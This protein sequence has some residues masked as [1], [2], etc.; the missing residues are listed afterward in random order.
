MLHASHN[1]AASLDM[2]WLRPNI[3]V[4]HHFNSEEH[5][6]RQRLRRMSAGADYFS[7]LQVMR[8]LTAHTQPGAPNE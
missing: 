5:V 6:F 7:S 2:L 4:R 8:R 3:C 1:T